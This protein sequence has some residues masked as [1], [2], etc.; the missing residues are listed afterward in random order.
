MFL[1]SGISLTI[2]CVWTF[3]ITYDRQEPWSFPNILAPYHCV[4]WKNVLYMCTLGYTLC[5]AMYCSW[6][7]DAKIHAFLVSGSFGNKWKLISSHG[8]RLAQS[9]TQQFR[10]VRCQK[11]NCSTL[12]HI[13][14]TPCPAN[15]CTIHFF[16]VHNDITL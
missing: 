9:F 2:S 4:H 11:L 10:I 7:F 1:K 3:D 5:G 8:S 15:T 14:H 6:V 12:L 16:Y 13:K